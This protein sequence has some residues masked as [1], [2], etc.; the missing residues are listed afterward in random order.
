MIC[1]SFKYAGN[2]NNPDGY[3]ENL[4]KGFEGIRFDDADVEQ[5]N[6]EDNQLLNFFMIII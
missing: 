6:F 1:E 4:F 5:E 2:S 3:E